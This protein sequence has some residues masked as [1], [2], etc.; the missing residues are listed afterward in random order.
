MTPYINLSAMRAVTETDPLYCTKPTVF[1]RL[2]N[3]TQ[4]V[5]GLMLDSLEKTLPRDSYLSEAQF[6]A[7]YPAIF[8]S[9]WVCI[10]R[11]ESLPNPGDYLAIR[12]KELSLIHI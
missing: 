5:E 11:S 8:E 9:D 4:A 1:S 2:I 10:G 3:P 12:L 7:E 6:N